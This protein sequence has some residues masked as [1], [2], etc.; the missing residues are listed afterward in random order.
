M[1]YLLLEF[2]RCIGTTYLPSF[3]YKLNARINAKTDGLKMH[4]YIS[5][6]SA[7]LLFLIKLILTK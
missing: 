6:P 4:H 7:Y 2:H 5:K 1:E 3:I